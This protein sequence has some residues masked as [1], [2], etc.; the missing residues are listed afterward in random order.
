MKA[1]IR[2]L[3]AA[4]LL[5]L[6]AQTA[7]ATWISE[8]LY[9]ALGADNGRVFVEIYGAP[10]T[11]LVDYSLE[12]VNGANG[13]IAPVVVL[14]GTI[15]A[16]GFFVV[17][18]TDGSGTQVANADLVLDFDFQ[19]GPDSILL[20]GPGGV[21]LD[22]IGYGVFG[23]GEVFAG[24]GSAAADPASGRSLARL[25][26]NQDTDDNALDFVALETPTPGEGVA[27]LTEPPALL[28]LGTGL[29]LAWLRRRD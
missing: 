2:G 5:L 21:L 1:I 16:D 11:S 4:L 26:A 27:M 14:S 29:V 7:R 17:A 19:N 18:D 13:A 22:A 25:F 10:G 24:E 12:G 9:D 8:V 23:A 6:Y 20:R 3:A 15:P 28:L